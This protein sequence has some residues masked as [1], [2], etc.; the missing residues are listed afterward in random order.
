MMISRFIVS[1]IV[2]TASWH[3]LADAKATGNLAEAPE[4]YLCDPVNSA[5]PRA[6]Q[7][8]WPLCAPQLI[9]GGAEKSGTTSM[10][11]YL[12]AHPDFL[13]VEGTYIYDAALRARIVRTLIR[14]AVKMRRA[15]TKR[16]GQAP[17]PDHRY[18]VNRWLRLTNLT[19]EQVMDAEPGK[20]DFLMKEMRFPDLESHAIPVRMGKEV[21]YWHPKVED[22]LRDF[23]HS[24]QQGY[25]NYLDL[26]PKIPMPPSSGTGSKVPAHLTDN[27]YKVT[28]EASP[29]YLDVPA[30]AWRIREMMPKT[31]LVFLFRDPTKRYWS[32]ACM[33]DGMSPDNA[34]DPK[35]KDFSK[36]VQFCLGGD[37]VGGVHETVMLKSGIPGGG[38]VKRMQSLSWPSLN[39]ITSKGW[40]VLSEELMQ[41]FSHGTAQFLLKSLY[42]QY[43]AGWVKPGSGF[44]V[45]QVLAMSSE[46]LFA[47]TPRAMAKVAAF[48]GLRKVD[49]SM[50][51]NATS[52]R[53]TPHF[54]IRHLEWSLDVEHMPK[55]RKS[56]GRGNERKPI[57]CSAETA[58]QTTMSDRVRQL[59]EAFYAGPSCALLKLLDEDWSRWGWP[60]CDKLVTANAAGQN[61]GAGRTDL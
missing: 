9:I 10:Y 12:K 45:D 48:A 7:E 47:D 17:G 5:I 36:N 59:L 54:D 6:D 41:C 58:A 57:V 8:S 28:G 55:T 21:R 46:E 44:P 26:F 11:E 42:V 18:D 61:G 35:L 30:S 16:T 50:W 53:Y 33:V 40:H 13:P 23:Q 15:N 3:Q 51:E 27:L 24:K 60:D 20:S 1:G 32:Q 14:R 38:G 52:Y 4:G 34:P 19:K 49:D 39:A 22:M 29:Q 31:R 2:A 43:F 25:G 37:K 56:S